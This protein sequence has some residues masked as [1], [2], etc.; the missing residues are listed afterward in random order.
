MRFLILVLFLLVTACAEKE[1][2]QVESVKKT[3]INKVIKCGDK[4]YL[5]LGIV[6]LIDVNGGIMPLA[7]G[8]YYHTPDCTY[9][10]DHGQVIGGI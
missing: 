5:T 2:P 10:I 8:V 9:M 4:L 1:T 7:D 6:F 3:P